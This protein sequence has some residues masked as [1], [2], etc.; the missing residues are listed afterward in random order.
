MKA[1]DLR[2]KSVAE[3]K[4]EVEHLLAEQFKQ[5]MAHSTGQ[6]DQTHKMRDNRRSVARLKTIIHEKMKNGEGQ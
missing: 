2:E 6:T 1:Q 5:R 4:A 3:L